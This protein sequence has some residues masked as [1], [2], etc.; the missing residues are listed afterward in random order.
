M[1][2]RGGQVAAGDSAAVSGPLTSFLISHSKFMIQSSFLLRQRCAAMRFLLRRLTSWMNSSCSDVSLCIF[3][4][5]WKSLRGRFVIWSTGK[6][7]FTWK[8][9]RN[10]L[11]IL[12]FFNMQRSTSMRLKVHPL[13]VEVQYMC[14][15]LI[16]L[17]IYL[18]CDC[19]AD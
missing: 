14:R 17:S 18:L 4:N 2:R 7:S 15:T 19:A 1:K 5:I 10:Y 16:V 11:F 3:T 12:L 9:S 13:C 6:G 8:K